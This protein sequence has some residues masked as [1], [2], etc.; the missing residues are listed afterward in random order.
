[1]AYMAVKVHIYNTTD[2][3][4]HKNAAKT[5]LARCGP[6]A[7]FHTFHGHAP[8]AA[9]PRCVVSVCNL[10][11][12]ETAGNGNHHDNSPEGGGRMAPQ[13]RVAAYVH[14][15]SDT[16]VELGLNLHSQPPS[17]HEIESD[18]GISWED[19]R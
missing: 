19:F 15:S 12:G 5:H 17:L 13:I 11:Y 9:P 10:S 8:D 4:N 2:M 1:M 18:R 7:C 3:A 6:W 16:Y 14:F